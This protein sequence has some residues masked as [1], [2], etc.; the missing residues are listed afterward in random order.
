MPIGEGLEPTSERWASVL[1]DFDRLHEERFSFSRS[2]AEVEIIG[3]EVDRFAMRPKP[4]IGAIDNRSAD[5]PQ[6]REREVHFGAAGGYRPTPVY[7]G[8]SLGVGFSANGPLIV[9]EDNT[10]VVV[11]PGQRVEVTEEN[12][13]AI[14]GG[15]M[16]T[17]TEESAATR[18]ELLMRAVRDADAT[19]RGS[20][21]SLVLGDDR[22]AA[23]GMFDR[24]GTPLVVSRPPWMPSLTATVRTVLDA[25]GGSLEPGDVAITNDPYGGGTHVNDFTLVRP[26]AAGGGYLAARFHTADIGGEQLGDPGRRR[27]TS[28]R[29]APGSCRCGC[30]APGAATATSRRCWTSTRACRSCCTATSPPPR[31]PSTRSTRRS[32]P[33]GARSSRSCSTTRARSWASGWPACAR[34]SGPP[35][36]GCGTAAPASTPRSSCA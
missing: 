29:R 33:T 27:S 10:S 34:A 9:E 20:L 6:A 22:H 15:L 7:A 17:L 18:H 25:Y 8:A 23:V 14:E 5:A 26:D 2:G 3:L 24:S 30:S 35:A 36:A 4:E 19:L 13:Y 12:V 1:K 21:P 28:G 16:T 31:P 32:R 11:L